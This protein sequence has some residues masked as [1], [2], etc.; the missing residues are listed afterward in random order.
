V[1]IASGYSETDR[2]KEALKIGAI[3][4]IKKP[5]YLHKIGIPVKETLLQ[6]Y[7]A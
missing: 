3:S 5:Y 2:V 6:R 4:Y 1:F 7:P